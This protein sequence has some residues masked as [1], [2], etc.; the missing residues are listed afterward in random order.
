[1]AYFNNE[2]YFKHS[3]ASAFNKIYNPGEI[4]EY[5][6]IYRCEKCGTEIGIAEG[7]RLPTS[8]DHCHNRSPKWRIIAIAKH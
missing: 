6:G 8:D 1:M 2:R 7:H 3:N 4:A 5:A